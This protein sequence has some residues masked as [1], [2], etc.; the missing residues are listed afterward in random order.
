M[1]VERVDARERAHRVELRRRAPA[2][3]SQA[4]LVTT[5]YVPWAARDA[6]EED[7]RQM[8]GEELPETLA[9]CNPGRFG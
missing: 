6:A 3:P 5:F 2:T 8:A 9:A 1:L 7:A 4:Q